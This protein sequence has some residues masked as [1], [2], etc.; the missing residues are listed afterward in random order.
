MEKIDV[1][2]KVLDIAID[3]MNFKREEKFATKYMKDGSRMT[4]HLYIYETPDNEIYLNVSDCLTYFF[5]TKDEFNDY[6]NEHF[7]VFKSEKEMYTN[8][9]DMTEETWNEW[10]EAE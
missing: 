9:W 10:N 6:L 8:D 1:R 4:S 2:K 3:V 7:K 5:E